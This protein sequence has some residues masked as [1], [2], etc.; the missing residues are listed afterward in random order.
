MKLRQ[1]GWIIQ[2]NWCVYIVTYNQFCPITNLSIVTVHLSRLSCLALQETGTV[3]KISK[4]TYPSV[5]TVQTA[6]QAALNHVV[7][8][9]KN[10]LKQY[11]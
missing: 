4:I 7:S 8:A 5:S 2:N 11:I 10:D 9:T 3:L 1:K 6:W